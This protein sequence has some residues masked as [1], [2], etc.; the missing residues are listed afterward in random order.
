MRS[1]GAMAGR[2]LKQ[3]RR[4]TLLTIIGI[5]LSVAL[6]SALGTMGQAFKDN[7]L[8]NIEATNGSYHIG[9]N[10]PSQELYDTLKNNVL[11]DRLGIYRAG[12]T[13]KLNDGYSVTVNQADKDAFSLMP[14]FLQKGR[15]PASSDEI[16]VE[17]WL[18]EQ[19]AGTPK[20]NGTTELQGPDG[21][22]HTY[23]IVGLLKNQ[24][25][26]QLQGAANAYTLWSAA[27]H[28][29]AESML[30]LTLKPGVSVNANLEQFKKLNPD[31]FTNFELLAVK[32]DS[33]DAGLNRALAVIFG[34]LVG[35]VVL[36]TIAV[37]YNAFHIAV[38]ERIRQF[39]LLRTL[40]ASPA[41]IRN[42]VFREATVLAAIGVPLGLVTG[43]FGLWLVLWLMTLGGLRILMMDEF[44]LTFHWWIMGG[45]LLVGFLAVY[46]AA[47][48]PARKASSVSPVEAVKG[49]GSI[50]RE[51]YRRLRIPSLLS[52]LGIEGK[53]ASNNIRRNRTKFRITTFSIVVSITLFIVFHYFT[54][55]VLGMTTTSNEDDRMA[56]QLYKNYSSDESG[57]FEKVADVAS[58]EAMKQLRDIPGVRGVY[59]TY[60]NLDSQALV[61]EDRFNAGITKSTGFTAPSRIEWKDQADLAV[62]ARVRLYDEARLK[63]AANYLQS[64][65]VDPNQLATA[66]G[67]VIVQTVKPKT[68]SGKKEL[69][70]I[71]RYKV[72]D[73]LLLN[74]GLGDNP[75]ADNVREVTVAGIL[76]QSPFNGAYQQNELTVIATKETYAKLLEA[77]PP[78]EGTLDFGTA[79]I[80]LDIALKDD[81]DPAPI[82]RKLEEIARSTTGVRLIDYAAEQKET[83]NFN[84]QMQIFVYGFLIII[85]GIGSLN[86]INTVQ[87]NLLLRR[88]EIGLLQAVGMTMGQIRKMAS[89]EGVW[90]G[91]IGGFWGIG[92]GFGLCYLLYK[93]LS[94][95][96]GFPFSF[97]WEASLIA[98]G[99]ALLVGLLSVQGPL[100]RMGK[101]NLL[102][103]LRD[104]A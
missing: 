77:A 99:L 55:Q 62:Q 60:N 9:Y 89:S 57:K 35:L 88:K 26:S 36:S 66:D 19:L 30:F 39:G 53:M 72:G 13:T 81:A 47:W 100:R 37:I 27:S 29:D 56:F 95:V 51:S 101:A 92:L 24:K 34:T 32:G 18:L 59:G 7:Y 44:Q 50:V 21:H 4:K 14:A 46:V 82:H 65:T 10:K 49:A 5:M 16:V 25:N 102:E 96:Q 17:Q 20:L 84:L 69:M 76:T 3:Q 74:M 33:A 97:P 22:S 45:S 104:E 1:Y 58:D 23:R 83:R 12:M 67:V 28:V 41:Q 2:Y 48:L 85:G 11:V 6:I 86:I 38:L 42:L 87:T 54:Q 52:L 71:T 103:E 73:K 79:R 8:S 91:V 64:G 70:P 98:C 31:L 61:P 93:Q 15:L 90:F 63:E 43:W 78:R 68:L 75:G 94:N 80:G 40:G